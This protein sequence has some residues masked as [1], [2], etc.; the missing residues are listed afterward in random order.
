MQ[1]LS[2]VP[3]GSIMVGLCH[4]QQHWQLKYPYLEI[5]GSWPLQNFDKLLNPHGMEKFVIKQHQHTTAEPL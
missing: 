1:L 5:I 2:H 3:L 4:I